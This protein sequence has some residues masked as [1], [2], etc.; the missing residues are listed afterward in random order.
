MTDK[1]RAQRPAERLNLKYRTAV[2]TGESERS[3]TF[4]IRHGIR[5]N[6]VRIRQGKDKA[7]ATATAITPKQLNLISDQFSII[8][9]HLAYSCLASGVQGTCEAAVRTKYGSHCTRCTHHIQP[10]TFTPSTPDMEGVAN[11]TDIKQPV[12]G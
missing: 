7:R 2:K 12:G 10:L 5:T 6:H 1:G 11:E 8:S 4:R 9:L 3:K